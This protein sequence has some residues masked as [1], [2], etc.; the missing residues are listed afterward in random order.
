MP[1]SGIHSS[2]YQRNRAAKRDEWKRRGRRCA[3]CGE[4]ID[5]DLPNTDPN[6]FQLDHI[7]SRDKFPD[8]EFDPLNWAPA[9]ASCNKHKSNGETPASIGRTSEPW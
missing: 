4:P 3:I 1:S 7:K 8:L 5:Y 2:A 9:H 6:H